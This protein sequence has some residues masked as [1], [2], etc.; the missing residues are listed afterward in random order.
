MPIKN[1]PVSKN[2]TEMFLPLNPEQ[3]E[4]LSR[5]PIT[6]AVD[7][8]NKI[9][10]PLGVGIKELLPIRKEATKSLFR[11]RGKIYTKQTL[12]TLTGT[13]KD[14]SIEM[15]LKP[16]QCPF[17]LEK[18]TARC[19]TAETEFFFYCN[20]CQETF[21]VETQ[22]L[23]AENKKI[24]AKF[25]PWRNHRWDTSDYVS[26]PRGM[27]RPAETDRRHLKTLLKKQR[28][29][30]HKLSAFLKDCPSN[31]MAC[32]V[33]KKMLEKAQKYVSELEALR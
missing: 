15:E 3:K 33:A 22:N 19:D 29:L 4:T 25:P 7:A 8:A 30:I 26:I 12:D 14:P 13:D 6:V 32:P 2:S 10:A 31:V 1:E 11:F 17:C 23:S 5:D 9:L 18:N 27:E 24:L 20:S 16:E 21:R 28:K